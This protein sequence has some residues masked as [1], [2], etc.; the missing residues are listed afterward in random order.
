MD[1]P[2]YNPDDLIMAGDSSGKTG[3]PGFTRIGIQP[4]N[5]R[6]KGWMMHSDQGWHVGVRCQFLRQPTCP[7]IAIP[8]TVAAILK[9]IQHQNAQTL[10]FDRILHKAIM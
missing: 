5:T 8:A 6:R 1:V 7:D 10:Q 3:N 2:A 9:R 4:G